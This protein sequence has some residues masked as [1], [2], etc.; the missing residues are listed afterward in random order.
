SLI[1]I[2]QLRKVYS[3]GKVA[4]DGMNLDIPSGISAIIGRNGA[5]KTTL[6]RIL[7]TQLMPTSGSV[8][9]MGLDIREDSS[10]IRKIV[11][12]IPQEASPIGVLTPLEQVKMYLVARGFSYSSADAEA[13]RALDD[14]GLGE[15][16]RLPADTLSGGMK[17]KIFVAMALASSSEIVF[18]DEPTTG[19]DPISR[20]EVWAAI[21]KL[22]S[23]ILLTTH[24]MEEAASLASYIVLVDSGRIIMG[25]TLKD[26]LS[27]FSGKVR[28][29]CRK[30]LEGSMEIGGIYIK[31]V[32]Y[33][34]AEN[35]VKNGCDVKNITLDDLFIRERIELE[36]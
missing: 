31:Y 29:E 4:I 20:Y 7:S 26:L 24:Y 14:V 33:G 32:D 11:C 19:L 2:R 21:R 1:E 35:Y 12:S 25:G 13:R 34:D 9:I 30:Y 16:M 18:L 3:N 10:R 36:P 28:V 8:K 15:S 23:D 5:G 6:M 27:E 22:G 17:R